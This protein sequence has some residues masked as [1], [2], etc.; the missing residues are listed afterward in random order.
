MLINSLVKQLDG[1]I[2]VDGSNGAKYTIEF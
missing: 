1:V 2:H